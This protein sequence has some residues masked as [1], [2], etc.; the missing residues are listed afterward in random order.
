MG[1]H[2]TTSKEQVSPEQK[3]MEPSGEPPNSE[4]G[5]ESSACIKEKLDNL[6]EGYLKSTDAKY[7]DKQASEDTYNKKGI[8][9]DQN[10]LKTVQKKVDNNNK[11]IVTNGT[12]ESTSETIKNGSECSQDK[13]T[14]SKTEAEETSSNAASFESMIERAL[15]DSMKNTEETY[16]KTRILEMCEEDHKA[17]PNSDS[18]FRKSDND[19]ISDDMSL[20]KKNVMF[21]KDHIERVLEKNFP[22]VGSKKEDTNEEGKLPV[23]PKPKQPLPAITPGLTLE[24]HM[25]KLIDEHLSKEN[26]STESELPTRPKS[27]NSLQ[28]DLKKSVTTSSVYESVDSSKHQ[29]VNA[30]SKPQP[31]LQS[32]SKCH[33][34]ETVVDRIIKKA[35][36][37]SFP[38]QKPQH[39]P[40]EQRWKNLRDEIYSE[41]DLDPPKKRTEYDAGSFPNHVEENRIRNQDIK[42]PHQQKVLIAGKGN[43]HMDMFHTPP[44]SQ[45]FYPPYVKPNLHHPVAYKQDHKFDNK[46]ES[47]SKYLGYPVKGCEKSGRPVSGSDGFQRTRVDMGPRSSMGPHHM[48]DVHMMPHMNSHYPPSDKSKYPHPSMVR[49]PAKP[50]EDLQSGIPSAMAPGPSPPQ[51][52]CHQNSQFRMPQLYPN[53]PPIPSPRE[54]F[55]SPT[56]TKDH[57]LVPANM[58]AN[59]RNTVS[60]SP[61]MS[62][63][64]PNHHPPSSP[65]SPRQPSP[66]VYQQ[67]KPEV[68]QGWQRQDLSPVS[69]NHSRKRDASGLDL[70]VKQTSQSGNEDQP[71]DLT[72]KRPRASPSSHFNPGYPLYPAQ[73]E[74]QHD[75]SKSIHISQLQ[76]SMDKFCQQASTD[77]PAG[78]VP[79]P[80]KGHE[81]FPPS[82][83]MNHP[84]WPNVPHPGGKQNIPPVVPN[85][86][87]ERPEVVRP[88]PIHQQHLPRMPIRPPMPH[89]LP[90]EAPESPTDSNSSGIKR[91]GSVSRHE[92]I[93]NIIGNHS[94][95]DILYLICRLCN[96]TYGSPYG[97]RKHFRNQ[98]GFEPRSEHTIVQTISGTKALQAP[99]IGPHFEMHGM[100]QM[101]IPSHPSPNPKCQSPREYSSH[102]HS[103]NNYE[104]PPSAMTLRQSA[105]SVGYP[106]SN[107]ENRRPESVPSITVNE[108]AATDPQRPNIKPEEKL[109]QQQK[110]PKY[111]ECHECGQ[112]FQLNDFGSYKRHCRTHG[113]PR[114]DPFVGGINDSSVP[115]HPAD[116]FKTSKT[117]TKE[118]ETLIEVYVCKYCTFTSKLSAPLEDHISQQHP[119][120]QRKL[121]CILCNGKFHLYEQFKIHMEKMHNLTAPSYSQFK[122]PETSIEKDEK[123]FIKQKSEGVTEAESLN[124]PS[125]LN[126]SYKAIPASQVTKMSADNAITSASPDSSCDPI[127]SSQADSQTKGLVTT[128][129]NSTTEV[130][131]GHKSQP[132]VVSRQVSCDSESDKSMDYTEMKYL[133]KKFKRKAFSSEKSESPESKKVKTSSGVDSPCSNSCASLDS[134]SNSVQM[135]EDS[136]GSGT[137]VCQKSLSKGKLDSTS[138]AESTQSEARHHLPF[139]WDRITR[140]QVGKTV[141]PAK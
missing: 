123:I 6:I 52:Y 23:K 21:L 31:A 109:E 18:D 137:D 38:P 56:S 67:T 136:E 14:P 16:E 131:S 115:L 47:Q 141:K 71:L 110:S 98:H 127:S 111:L 43:N 65:R 102:S 60:K 57:L 93:Q 119:E 86:G 133:H 120:K 40:K 101:G 58:Y 30:V 20:S 15:N 140:S 51:R 63:S 85:P 26:L 83:M 25:Q 82:V 76:N 134:D 125:D 122:C 80:V 72:C 53:N 28:G 105:G 97:F 11:E 13:S 68:K 27:S 112:T 126:K 87:P 4:V 42:Y 77:M 32:Q 128:S 44:Q 139:V 69:P 135:K 104:R 64:S 132:D 117:L 79:P 95:S 62:R 45:Y 5:T 130:K 106:P 92:P 9:F 3:N 88:H 37:D 36:N 24:Q 10:V 34:V 118:G 121:I 91:S 46:H 50:M 35:V 100:N 41:C 124:I 107:H 116:D 113:N 39:H 1:N 59:N 12:K 81:H 7:S 89:H 22:S 8:L 94:P 48:H 129:L 96:Q 55:N 78:R 75:I 114:M 138:A 33:S 49:Y 103:P 90:Q 73:M 74:K 29:T 99:P 108:S 19:K 70:S 84:H 17:H 2:M 54:Y 66:S 61:V